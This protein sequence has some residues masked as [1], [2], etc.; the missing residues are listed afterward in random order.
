MTA[1]GAS[2]SASSSA[3]TATAVLL[4]AASSS[5]TTKAAHQPAPYCDCVDS[6]SSSSSTAA[7]AS[8]LFIT[9]RQFYDRYVSKRRPVLFKGRQLASSILS[10]DEKGC[11]RC[12]SDSLRT[13]DGLR[14]AV[15]G[16]TSAAVGDDADD[17]GC[18]AGEDDATTDVEANEWVPPPSVV[19][20]SEDGANRCDSTAAAAT[21]SFSP[22]HSRVVRVPFR[23]L[24]ESLRARRKRR[25]LAGKGKKVKEEEEEEKY[26][27]MTTQTLPLDDEGRP[28]LCAYP[29]TE[30]VRRKYLRLRPPLFGNLVPM[31]VN[32]W[33]GRTPTPPSS[34]SSG[35][36]HDFHDNV[37]CLLRGRKT[38]EIAPPSSAQ[39]VGGCLKMRGEVLKVHDNGRI[40]YREQ[41]LPDCGGGVD[42]IRPDGAVESVERV[43]ELE[44]RREEIEALLATCCDDDG[45]DDSNDDKKNK[46]KRE[47]DALER[48]LDD[49]EEQ[50]LEYEIHNN[51]R[52]FRQDDDDDDGDNSGGVSDG[53]EDEDEEAV[54]AFFGRRNVVSAPLPKKKAK[55]GCRSPSAT[56]N[57]AG[58]SATPQSPP[59]SPISGKNSKRTANDDDDDDDH[60]DNLPPNFVVGGK[61]QVRFETVELEAGDVLYLPAGWFHE[62]KSRGDS[63][64]G[65]SD[66]DADIANV[67][68]HMA[69]NYWLHPPDVDDASSFERPYLSRFWQRDWEARGLDG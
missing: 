24:L 43:L 32:L 13:I 18:D 49:I 56:T 62:V 10:N 3:A 28:A 7:D 9:P 21:V 37:Y 26:Y 69:V 63:D 2:A 55:L 27:Y 42:M 29:V 36:H 33:I 25:E 11:C 61:D 50:L 40:V 15:F 35:L 19:A 17:G 53:E 14:D 30:L 58:S 38:F 6:S 48:E 45:E 31:N 64:D 44:C 66:D 57:A 23:T 65:A 39:G 59:R 46:K 4:S 5:S 68:V 52:K 51:S 34:T 67:G 60:D 54:G 41:L 8:P 1:E 20:A 12:D 47:H 22:R 16:T